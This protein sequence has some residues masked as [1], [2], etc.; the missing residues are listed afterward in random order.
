MIAMTKVTNLNF[1]LNNHWLIIVPSK[2]KK[3]RRDACFTSPTNLKKINISLH[4]ADDEVDMCFYKANRIRIKFLK[5]GTPI[6]Q[7]FFS[8]L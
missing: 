3:R 4:N 2:N 7:E 6:S 8:H 5:K 1:C